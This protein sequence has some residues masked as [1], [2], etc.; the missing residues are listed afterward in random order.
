MEMTELTSLFE[1]RIVSASCVIS[2]ELWLFESKVYT[3]PQ[4]DPRL[5]D[6]FIWLTQITCTSVPYPMPLRS[7]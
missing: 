5:Q 2:L 1:I 4:I 6:V 3:D 7:L